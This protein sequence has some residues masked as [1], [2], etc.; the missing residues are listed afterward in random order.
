VIVAPYLASDGPDVVERLQDVDFESYLTDQ[1]LVKVDIAS[2]AHGLEVRSP[3]LD[4]GLVELAARLPVE[5]KLDGRTGKRLLRDVV[6]TWTP[7]H[8]ADRPKQGFGVPLADWF[9]GDL[10]M[11]A[12]DVL[13]DDA[14][15]RRGIFRRDAIERLL[16]EHE[17]GRSDR[18]SKIW[19]LIQLELWLRTFIDQSPTG[20]M[21]LPL[22]ALAAV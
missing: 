19:G 17:S 5:S 12:R 16:S 13:L 20:P 11:L 4:Q 15:T 3:L 6:R 22:P 2:M 7:A 18:S 14:A 21:E 9:R 10:R 8:I 1:L